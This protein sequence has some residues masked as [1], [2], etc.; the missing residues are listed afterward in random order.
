MWYLLAGDVSWRLRDGRACHTRRG[1]RSKRKEGRRGTHSSSLNV[2]ISLTSNNLCLHASR[3]GGFGTSGACCPTLFCPTLPFLSSSFFSSV[4]GS[5]PLG[6]IAVHPCP[7]CSSRVGLGWNTSSWPSTEMP[8]CCPSVCCINAGG[9]GL[10][11]VCA[12][13]CCC[14]CCCCC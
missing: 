14:C 1:E 10:K 13:C 5:G 3:F 2:I 7:F 8:L 4:C 9:Y 6:A 12:C 11:L